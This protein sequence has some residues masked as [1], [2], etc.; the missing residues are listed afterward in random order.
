MV[1]ELWQASCHGKQRFRQTRNQE[2]Q[3]ESPQAASPEARRSSSLPPAGSH[4]AAGIG[5]CKRSANSSGQLKTHGGCP[6]L[7]FLEGGSGNV[8][9]ISIHPRAEKWVSSLQ[10]LLRVRYLSLIRSVR[11]HSKL[12][13]SK[14]NGSHLR[15][16]LFVMVDETVSRTASSPPDAEPQASSPALPSAN[17][18][19]SP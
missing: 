5:N 18:L 16:P 14:K 7:S 8:I 1:T 11:S 3:E 12:N 6:I 19:P 4:H 2:T 17:L 10:L 13:R 9:T 15:E